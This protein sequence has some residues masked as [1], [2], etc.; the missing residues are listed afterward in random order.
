MPKYHLYST[1]KVLDKA[2]E[3]YLFLF[4]ID[5]PR[6]NPSTRPI[7]ADA[8]SLT[9][10]GDVSGCQRPISCQTDFDREAP[11]AY[12]YKKTLK[13]LALAVGYPAT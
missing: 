6:N 3:Y 5:R 10:V 12:V 9:G 8:D 4:Q 2:T 13:T 7:V 1:K 11:E